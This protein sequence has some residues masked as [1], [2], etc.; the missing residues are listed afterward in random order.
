MAKIFAQKGRKTFA[1][2]VW[3]FGGDNCHRRA[4]ELADIWG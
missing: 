4:E 2:K 3:L 1:Y